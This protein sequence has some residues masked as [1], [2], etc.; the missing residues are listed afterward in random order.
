ME[1]LQGR[2]AHGQER[3]F[4]TADAIS[5]AVDEAELSGQQAQDLLSYLE[6][7]GVEI[8]APGE[9]APELSEPIGGAAAAASGEAGEDGVWGDDAGDGEPD[10]E[11]RGLRARLEE[12]RRPEVDLTVEP[13]LD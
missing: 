11:G 1:E 8:L 3:G 7:H 12:L 2:I 13:S 5:S 6:E 10:D 4:L 9:T